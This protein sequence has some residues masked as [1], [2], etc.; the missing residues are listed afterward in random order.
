M[1]SIQLI[2]CFTFLLTTYAQ[3]TDFESFY[4]TITKTD[5]YSITDSISEM[6]IRKHLHKAVLYKK[7]NI[8]IHLSQ[9]L[10]DYL[11]YK[12]NKHKES[13]KLLKLY[14]TFIPEANIPKI[15]GKYYI[16][17]ADA[18]IFN[19]Q[20]KASLEIAKKG[21]A[22]LEKHNDSSL[23]E[24]GYSYLKAA[25]TSMNLNRFTE[26]A[27]YYKK[28][29]QLFTFQ[30]DTLF[31]LWSK[32]GLGTLFSNNG[33]LDEAEKTRAPIYSLAKKINQEQV[34]AMAHL[35]SALNA[36]LLDQQEKELY[37]IRE[38]IKCEYKHSDI[39][40][41]VH[42][43]S[44]SFATSVYAKNKKTD[45]SDYYLQ[46]LKPIIKAQKDN[47]FLHNYYLLSR[48]YN[49]IAN[50]DLTKSEIYLKEFIKKIK[51]NKADPN[52]LKANHLLADIYQKLN[53]PEKA[54]NYFKIYKHVSDSLNREQSKTKFAYTQS[55][56]EAEKKDLK[57]SHQEKEIKVLDLENRQ[58][59]Q[60]LIYSIISI[61]LLLFISYLILTKI[62][63][64]NEQKT[65][66]HLSQS[67]INAQES[68]RA[69]LARDLHD[70]I[71]Q[72]LILLKKKIQKQDKAL[73]S[74]TN[75]ILEEMRGI[76]KSL[77]PSILKQLGLTETLIQM[78]N[79]VDEQSNLFFTFEI[80]T[81]DGLLTPDYEVN[82]YRIVQ[83]AV[84]NIIKHA[85]ATAVEINVLKN[86]S[87]IDIQII[88][89]GNGFNVEEK[90]MK[91]NSFGLQTLKERVNILK[92][93]ISFHS[94]E[95]GTILKITVPFISK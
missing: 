69:R 48:G 85:N 44:L 27:L 25:E 10:S 53:K 64:R 60:T 21:I 83:E 31:L 8:T 46:Q 56:F 67:L 28:A 61:I 94:N 73:A 38:A 66:K 33:L 9:L 91:S 70:G 59:K 26:S 29:E 68:E 51:H 93:D 77:H 40:P 75:E 63:I 65:Q 11:L 34:A 42:T 52:Y 71:G 80:Q 72:Q 89:N 84:N 19:Q 47:T 76:T 87:K 86:T 62:R 81:I 22:V 14:E 82:L 6:E 36:S 5:D 18:A 15:I 24:F 7:A 35:S 74:D 32:N 23:Y 50:N 37:H 3:Q 49:S 4:N 45:S 2:F 95:H 39:Y 54:L 17:Y 43:L 30:K 1:K 88:D 16:T 78:I 58:K 92:G 79:S 90:F 55:L 20:H 13:Y 41:I 12:K 57:I